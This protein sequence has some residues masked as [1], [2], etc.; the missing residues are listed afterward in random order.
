MGYWFHKKYWKMKL[1]VTFEWLT[2]RELN[3][4]AVQVFMRAFYNGLNQ[5]DS[6][7]S[8]KVII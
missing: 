8:S 1:T 3:F 7:C 2:E 6:S 5:V 4:L